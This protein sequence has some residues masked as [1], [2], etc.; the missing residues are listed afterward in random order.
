MLHRELNG[1]YGRPPLVQ[2]VVPQVEK[3]E[4]V[5]R[6]HEGM[7]GGHRAFRSTLEQVRRRGFWF[8]WRRDVQSYCRQCQNCISYHRGRLP[9]TGQLQNLVTGSSMERCHVDITSPH[10][11]TA[12]GS[13]YILTCVDAF[14]EV[15]TESAP[16]S[17]IIAGDPASVVPQQQRPRRIVHLPIRYGNYCAL[18]T[19]S[20]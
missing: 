2:L 19:I 14:P 4:F 18:K 13:Q 15:S 10:P 20:G 11:R 9:R 3:M 17:T 5:K 7:T 6:C 16:L 1:M 8:G 12:S